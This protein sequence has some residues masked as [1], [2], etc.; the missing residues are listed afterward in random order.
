MTPSRT[1]QAIAHAHAAAELYTEL[2]DDALA[3]AQLAEAAEYDALAA[4]A[5]TGTWRHA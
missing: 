4:G 1:Q 3:A 2:A 5:L